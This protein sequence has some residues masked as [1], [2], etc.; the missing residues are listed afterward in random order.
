MSTEKLK[1]TR[2]SNQIPQ[3]WYS[4]WTPRREG[5]W[6]NLTFGKL[7]QPE[8]GYFLIWLVCQA[9]AIGICIGAAISEPRIWWRWLMTGGMI[10]LVTY[11][12]YYV[13]LGL[14][15]VFRSLDRWL[16]A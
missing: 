2:A 7:G 13:M 5:M 11:A 6:D 14:Q 16:S 1:G 4:S 9:A 12:L 15:W 8:V 3:E 10:A